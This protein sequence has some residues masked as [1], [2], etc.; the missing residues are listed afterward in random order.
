MAEVPEFPETK[1][2]KDLTVG[3]TYKI[4]NARKVNTHEYGLKVVIDYE[5]EDVTYSS[6][7]PKR[8]NTYFLAKDGEKL[9]ELITEA[10]AGI[11]LFKFIGGYY[12]SLSF[13]RND[14]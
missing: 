7:V 10:Q 11:V 2:L 8:L 13:I 5:D 4:L 14:V 9:K 3:K 6:F 12:N 1:K